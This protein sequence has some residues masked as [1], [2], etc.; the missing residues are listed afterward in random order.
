MNIVEEKI[1]ALR[2]FTIDINSN[3][4]LIVE[5]NEH[6]LIDM[7]I[8]D[9]LYELG[10]DRNGIDIFDNIPY[11]FITQEYK[12]SVG[13]PA[14]RVTLRDTGDFHRSFKIQTLSDSF[15]IYATDIKTEL[16]VAKYGD[17]IMGLTDENIALFAVDY[18]YPELLKRLKDRL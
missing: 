16:L 5:S 3:I 1:Q 8:Q 15:E 17:S 11:T 4:R 12:R 9:Q 7:N 6:I 2:D 10:V 18:V 13:Q 14:D